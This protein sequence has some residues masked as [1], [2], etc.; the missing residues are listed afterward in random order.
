MKAE[1]PKQS[2]AQLVNAVVANE[3]KD[4]EQQRRWMYVIEKRD[5]NQILKEE[6]VE[7]KDG[8]LYRVIAKDGVPLNAQD[9]QQEDARIDNLL[10]NPDEQ[11]KVKQRQED[12]EKKLQSL[13]RLMPAAFLYEYDV[14]EGG[15]LR[16]KFTPNPNY[17][18]PTYETRVV[19]SLG[20]VMLIEPQQL[21][22]AKVSGKVVKDVKFGFGLF[23]HIDNGGTIE[24]GR[25]QVGPGQWKTN[26]INLQLSG[27]LVFFKTLNKQQ[28]ETRSDFR[29]IGSDTTLAQASELLKSAR[30]QA[31]AK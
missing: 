24:F 6:Q 22:L 29:S 21:R 23:G 5:G 11:L 27:T 2:P 31:S 14:M 17:D 13:M 12:D 16:V 7:T 15:L 30:V 3:L 19:A 26:L 20:G 8:P 4:R 25:K 1:A 10:H 18:A 28:Y 9:R